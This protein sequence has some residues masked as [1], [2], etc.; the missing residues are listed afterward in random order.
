MFRN[1]GKNVNHGEGGRDLGL[2]IITTGRRRWGSD[3]R[4]KGIGRAHTPLSRG[5]GSS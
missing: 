3:S 1:R 4:K 2:G 5:E